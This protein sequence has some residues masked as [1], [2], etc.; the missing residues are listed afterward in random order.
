MKKSTKIII[1]ILTI[2]P[3]LYLLF[4]MVFFFS[5]FFFLQGHEDG[6]FLASNFMILFGLHFFTII[7]SMG[8]LVFYVINIF[9]N[10]R[11]KSNQKTLWAVI[12]FMGNMIA[13]PVYFYLF[14]WKEPKQESIE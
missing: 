5:S 3:I 14:I 11:V 6:I 9:R 1:G 7:M 10:D 12:L 4:F 2:W 8:L 13:M